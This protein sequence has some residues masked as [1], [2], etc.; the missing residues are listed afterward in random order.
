MSNPSSGGKLICLCVSSGQGII[1]RSVRRSPGYG[2][3]IVPFDSVKEDIN[4]GDETL[5]GHEFDGAGGKELDTIVAVGD[6]IVAR[7]DIQGYRLTPPPD[8]C[9]GVLVGAKFPCAAG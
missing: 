4:P 2:D 5:V 8:P 1:H 6:L 3:V 7:A 9:K